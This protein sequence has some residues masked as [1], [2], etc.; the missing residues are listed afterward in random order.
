MAEE[1]EVDRLKREIK[2]NLSDMR[3][4][5]QENL[6]SNHEPAEG[7]ERHAPN[8]TSTENGEDSPTSPEP[9]E[10]QE[11][12]RSA[13]PRPVRVP[14]GISHAYDDV[15]LEDFA[16][17][18]QPEKTET[19]TKHAHDAIK[20]PERKRGGGK[21][22]G[23]KDIMEVF[24]NEC[25][26]AF[27]EWMID[28]VVDNTL[29]FAEWVL[30][31]PFKSAGGTV[32]TT[33]E[34]QNKKSIYDIGGEVYKG[35][36]D[37]FRK[38][39]E[40]FDEAHKEL[41]ENLSR[42]AS[43]VASEWKVW[44]KEPRF[45]SRLCQIAA[46]AQADSQSPEAK[47]MERFNKTPEI[48]QGLFKKEETVFKVAVG[49]ATLEE[50]VNDKKAQMPEEFTQNFAA[51]EQIVK[52]K[53][54]NAGRFKQD[55]KQKVNALKTSLGSD[56][57]KDI[58]KSLEEIADIVSQ[59][60]GDSAKLNKEVAEKIKNIK[61]STESTEGHQ[62]II[63]EHIFSRSKGHYDKLMENID[64]IQEAYADNP[65]MM[66]KTCKEYMIHIANS[67]KSAK[68]DTDVICGNNIKGKFSSSRKKA[69]ESVAK[70]TASVDN[71]LLNQHEIGTMSKAQEKSEFPL[72]GNKIKI[73]KAVRDYSI[74][75]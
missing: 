68:K 40:V 29:D 34:K 11:D 19:K 35:R 33:T 23:G 31:T 48:I 69:V 21:A 71:F 12:D 62:E 39:K 7:T 53:D 8:P 27:Y 61:A 18:G 54:R 17:K 75:A 9:A 41:T 47:V 50:S 44:G 58:A 20:P 13:P 36:M 22:G 51:L 4:Q 74:G 24:W 6:R 2:E 3:R 10:A 43:G 15:P 46:A 60:G 63:K 59:E 45:F 65:E 56:A 37:G 25:I 49:I 5:T 1:S 32:E 28:T 57:Y 52:N 66:Q 55:V 67:I 26:I 72:E 70:A 38:N 16:S 73:L 64:K 42:E 14:D 30:F